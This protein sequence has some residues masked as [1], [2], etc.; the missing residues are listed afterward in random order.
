MGT[1]TQA[2]TVADIAGRPVFRDLRMKF[3]GHQQ[4]G[5]RLCCPTRF[6]VTGREGLR[7]LDVQPARV[8]NGQ[9]VKVEPSNTRGAHGAAWTPV[10]I[11]S[12]K[13]AVHRILR[14]YKKN[15][16]RYIRTGACH[17]GQALRE[18]RA[19][20]G[21]RVHAARWVP[22]LASLGR[23]DNSGCRLGATAAVPPNMPTRPV[24]GRTRWP[25]TRIHRPSGC[26]VWVQGRAEH[27][28]RPHRRRLV[29]IP[30]VQSRAP[31]HR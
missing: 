26:R 11:V 6:R 7:G 29:D 19:V 22:A 14:R 20:P 31:A 30:F 10:S 24:G 13:N 23:D 3:S 1:I 15:S 16:E 17:P 4:H 5:A 2:Y 21:P 18:Q 27:R 12:R 25:S 28:Q 9:M 8:S